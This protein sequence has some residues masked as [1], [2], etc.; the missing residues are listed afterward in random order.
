MTNR[1]DPPI[2]EINGGFQL[3]VLSYAMVLRVPRCPKNP[4][5]Q[6]TAM[7][8]VSQRSSPFSPIQHDQLKMCCGLCRLS[9]LEWTKLDLCICL[10]AARIC[11]LGCFSS[12]EKQAGNAVLGPDCWP[13][14]RMLSTGIL[15][16]QRIVASFC[17]G[18]ARSR[19]DQKHLRTQVL[20]AESC[21][22][23]A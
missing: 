4:W 1:A 13:K 12:C 14:P 11:R 6:V 23:H 17:A 2:K 18:T 3:R 16:Q 7:P 22:I 20:L 15:Q 19:D 8:R 10:L 9:I 21:T 5:R